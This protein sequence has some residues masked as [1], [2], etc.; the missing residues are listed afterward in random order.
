MWQCSGQGLCTQ[1]ICCPRCPPPPAER[2]QCMHSQAVHSSTLIVHWF[3]MHGKRSRLLHHNAFLGP[4]F[5]W[6]SMLHSS[7]RAPRA[8]HRMWTKLIP[9]CKH[10]PPDTQGHIHPSIHTY[11]HTYIHTSIHFICVQLCIRTYIHAYIHRYT[12]T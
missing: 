11:I 1:V 2:R 3:H 5:V 12:A 9:S 6:R 7:Y 8:V 10:G 4:G